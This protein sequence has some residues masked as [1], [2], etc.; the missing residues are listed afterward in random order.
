MIENVAICSRRA[1]AAENDSMGICSWKCTLTMCEVNQA[2]EPIQNGFVTLVT[3][4]KECMTVTRQMLCWRSVQNSWQFMPPPPASF[5]P[6]T[7]LISFWLSLFFHARLEAAFVQW[8][9][10]SSQREVGSRGIVVVEGVVESFWC[11]PHLLQMCNQ[12]FRNIPFSSWGLPVLKSVNKPV[13][14]AHFPLSL[15]LPLLPAHP[16]LLLVMWKSPPTHTHTQ[17]SSSQ[18]FQ[19]T[20][21]LS[22]YPDAEHVQDRTRC[23]PVPL[24]VYKGFSLASLKVP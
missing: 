4:V 3:P 1:I 20:F 6:K 21:P 10:S 9:K 2:C 7:P 16:F 23:V 14:W 5:S 24:M 18:F 8:R 19:L 11:C 22:Q 12:H 17:T 15:P 13:H